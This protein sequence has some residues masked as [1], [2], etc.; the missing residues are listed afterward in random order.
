[1][2]EFNYACQMKTPDKMIAVVLEKEMMSNRKLWRGPVGAMMGNR[3]YLDMTF[4]FDDTEVLNEKVRELIER[5]ADIVD[6][7]HQ[8]LL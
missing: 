3:L 7:D 4:D 5:I 2:I 1:M 8:P 6:D